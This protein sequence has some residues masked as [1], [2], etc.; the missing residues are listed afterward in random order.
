MVTTERHFVW[1]EPTHRTHRR[2]FSPLTTTLFTLNVGNM[3]T[4]RH[5]LAKETS[6][7]L[8]YTRRAYELLGS[9]TRLHPPPPPNTGRGNDSASSSLQLFDDTAR[10]RRRR[11]FSPL[12]NRRRTGKRNVGCATGTTATGW[13][14][15]SLARRVI[16]EA[17]AFRDKRAVITDDDGETLCAQPRDMLAGGIVKDIVELIFAIIRYGVSRI[18]N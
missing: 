9:L 1:P 8:V 12:I 16:N 5:R 7:I 11:L 13:L 18:A 17:F 4:R 15:R 10:R 6:V 14:A 2:S 3:R